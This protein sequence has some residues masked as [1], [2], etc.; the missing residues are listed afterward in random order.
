M[1]N[2]LTDIVWRCLFDLATYPPD[3]RCAG[4]ENQHLTRAIIPVH[5]VVTVSKNRNGQNMC[6]SVNNC[7]CQPRLPSYLMYIIVPLIQ[8]NIRYFDY[9]F[10][11]T[12]DYFWLKP[13]LLPTA[14]NINTVKYLID[15]HPYFLS[16]H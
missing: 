15:N 1:R 13:T 6:Q 16:L 5:R 7:Y 11:I 10:L 9:I 14:E 2:E 3:L 4:N 8:S 12:E